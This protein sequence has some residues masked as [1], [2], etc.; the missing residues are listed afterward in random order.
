MELFSEGMNIIA[1]GS[2]SD[3][4]HIECIKQWLTSCIENGNLPVIC[5]EQSCKQPIPLPD[6]KELLTPQEMERCQKFEWKKIRDSNANVWECMTD[7]CDNM[8]IKDDEQ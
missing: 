6:L 2:C 1:L 5:P 8:F 7:G 3:V 4:Y